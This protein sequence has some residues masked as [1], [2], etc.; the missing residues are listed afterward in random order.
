MTQEL[1]GKCMKFFAKWWCS[2]GWHDWVYFY[3]SVPE[4]YGRVDRQ[5]LR[6]GQ[7]EVSVQHKKELWV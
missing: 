4:P 2:L 7:G 3:V 1:L 5:C 6:C